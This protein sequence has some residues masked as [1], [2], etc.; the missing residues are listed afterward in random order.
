M[1]YLHKLP[2]DT[3]KID[4][5]FVDNMAKEN[6]TTILVKAIISLSKALNL[7][8]VAE[9]VEEDSQKEHLRELECDI[10]QGYLFSKPLIYSDFIKKLEETS[11]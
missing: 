10:M 8:T 2:I 3:I 5:S 6:D 7:T 11:N 4:K 9:G 1:N